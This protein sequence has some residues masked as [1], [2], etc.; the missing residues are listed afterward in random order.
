MD[1]KAKL[2]ELTLKHGKAY[3]I[4]MV[5]EALDP[6]LQ[7]VVADTANPFDDVAYAAIKEPLKKALI[8]VI[9]NLKV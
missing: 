1:I 2:I 9:N 8:D 3:A 4:D 5:I 6:A 7:K